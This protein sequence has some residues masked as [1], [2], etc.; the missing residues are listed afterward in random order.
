MSPLIHWKRQPS[1]QRVCVC[2]YL[3]KRL[4]P[5]CSF[6]T[7]LHHYY[8]LRLQLHPHYEFQTN[9]NR[10]ITSTHSEVSLSLHVLIFQLTNTYVQ[11]TY[12]SV[13]FQS[14]DMTRHDSVIEYMH[15]W[16]C[17]SVCS[18]TSLEC[19]VALSDLWE[20]KTTCKQRCESVT[21]ASF[22]TRSFSWKVLLA[23]LL[24][25]TRPAKVRTS[26]IEVF[27]REGGGVALLQCNA[28]LKWSYCFSFGNYL[29]K[30]KYCFD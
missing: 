21:S 7:V 18:E 25:H 10:Q 19:C 29:L 30:I 12:L 27:K 13:S 2:V 17:V 28:N 15:R 5:F 14:C 22:L 23:V 26:V 11:N 3:C 9:L 6:S 16:A 20:W 8:F 4:S 1:A 24:L